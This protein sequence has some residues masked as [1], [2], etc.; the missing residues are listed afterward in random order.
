AP[1][2]AQ[3]EH[4]KRLLVELEAARA[5]Q[6]VA[7][8]TE[9]EL[10]A[11]HEQAQRV[12]NTLAFDEAMTR[13]RLI[14][15]QLVS[16]GWDVGPNGISTESIGQELDV[17]HQPTASGRGRADYVLWGANGKPLAVVEAKKP[18]IDAD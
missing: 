4:M 3:E 5:K 6:P 9:A 1:V 10:Q 17:D 14:D 16:A 8:A 7:V 12:A 2:A 15:S 13:R 18:A 11:A